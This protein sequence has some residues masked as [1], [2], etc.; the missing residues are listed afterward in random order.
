[1]TILPANVNAK[2]HSKAIICRV[3][4]ARFN[5]KTQ[6]KVLFFWFFAVVFGRDGA[7]AT[8]GKIYVIH[9]VEEGKN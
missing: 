5:A 4:G 8:R 6:E 1:M 3:N 2:A 7:F 9:D